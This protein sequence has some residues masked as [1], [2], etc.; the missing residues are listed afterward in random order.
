MESKLSLLASLAV[1]SYVTCLDDLSVAI[2]SVFCGVGT[3]TTCQI[4][5]NHILS[6]QQME[7]MIINDVELRRVPE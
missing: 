7:F 4:S 1:S 3:G 5:I 6:L 2:V